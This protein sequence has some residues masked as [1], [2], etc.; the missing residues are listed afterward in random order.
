MMKDGLYKVQFHTSKGTGRGV[1]Y[2]SGGK[3]RGGNSAFA[4]IGTYTIDGDEIMARVSTT[5][6]TDDPQF[7]P[8]FGIDR[9]TIVMRGEAN[10]EVVDFHG[11]ALQVPHQPLTVVFTPISD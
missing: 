10:G 3:L 7:Q 2:A 5:R 1:V 9:V 11:T 8:L 6:H 4:F